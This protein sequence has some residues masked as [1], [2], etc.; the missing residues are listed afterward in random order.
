MK[1]EIVL[2]N[3]LGGKRANILQK[4]NVPILTNEVCQQWYREEKKSLI[5][6]D[7]AMCA[8]LE[9]GGKDSCQ[10]SHLMPRLIYSTSYSQ[11]PFY[12]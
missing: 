1:I 8:G 11:D 3:K 2:I 5:I 4:V 9:A 12:S 10:V 6:V 7:T